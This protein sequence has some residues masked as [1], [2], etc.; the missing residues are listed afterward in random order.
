VEL[1]VNHPVM[2][3]PETLLEDGFAAVYVA[4]GFPKDASLNIEGIDGEG[5]FTALDL[6]ERVARGEEPNLGSKVLVIGGGNTAM[7]AARTAQRLV[8]R[9]VTVVY[10]R[11]RAEMP[12]EEE[13]LRDLFDE[14]NE[15]I[16]LASP[17]GVVL[18]DG[19]VAALA[20]V[21]NELG[22]PGPDGRR[23]PV[24][25]EGSEFELATDSIIIAIGQ[26]SDIA[27]LDGS[28]VV[29]KKNGTIAV[30]PEIGEA[31]DCVYA[32]G[33]AAR[34]PAI[35]IEAC[36]DGRRAAEAICQKF[37]IAFKPLAAQ[38]PKL[39]W[40]EILQVKRV[41]ARKEAQQKPQTLPIA[42]RKGFDLVE[43][44]LPE[45]RA[46]AEA[47]RC[48]QCSTLCDKCVEV[49]PNRANLTYRIEPVHWVLSLL[50]CENGKLVVA[51]EE[52]FE[53]AQPRQI[54]HIDDF[55]NAC[56]N[57][58]TFCVHRGK[59]YEEKPRLFLREA[60]FLLEEDN[61]FFIERNTLRR[62]EG[63]R[64]ARLAIEGDG[65]RFENDR[66]KASLSPDFEVREMTLKEAFDGTLSLKEAAEMAVLLR[67]ITT[68]LPFLIDASRGG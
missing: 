12:A 17:E 29:I 28:R 58:A 32:G 47:A 7:D 5:V 62:R 60:D 13:E 66:L 8:G 44:T 25:I 36:A 50:S 41:R 27:F 45:E 54:V 43:Q 65:F 61:A 64:E 23:R 67:G 30:D 52:V 57:C 40:E 10:R 49:C 3:P 1:K 37:G 16:E 33:D 24:R 55:C 21:R 9:P 26:R 6:L 22:E 34:G 46:R 4:P 53:V 19:R 63:G 14:G 18:K 39:S 42:Q 31:T 11:S 15:L 59:P 51:G 2:T 20:C 56:G 48:L 38:T 68:S 35:I